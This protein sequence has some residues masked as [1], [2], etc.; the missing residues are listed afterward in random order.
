MNAL[1]TRESNEYDMDYPAATFLPQLLSCLIACDIYEAQVQGRTAADISAK[2]ASECARRV[3]DL[4]PPAAAD[5]T[6]DVLRE[7][8]RLDTDLPREERF[9]LV[10]GMLGEW[11]QARAASPAPA[12]REHATVPAVDPRRYSL[13]TLPEILA[14][15]VQFAQDDYQDQR[16]SALPADVAWNVAYTCACFL[17]QHAA[18]GPVSVETAVAYEGLEIARAMP[19]AERVALAAQLIGTIDAGDG[20]PCKPLAPEDRAELI[21]IL[22]SDLADSVLS[23][24]DFARG[25]VLDTAQRGYRALN[26]RTDAELLQWH[27]DSFDCEFVASDSAYLQPA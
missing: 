2:T 11:A 4:L 8:L 20:D 12:P 1:T 19:Y 18:A 9:A 27:A 26:T 15:I 21:G 5:L 14:Q 7:K 6:A 24:R 10:D 25:F 13:A 22:A 23:D 3:A 16:G 17:A